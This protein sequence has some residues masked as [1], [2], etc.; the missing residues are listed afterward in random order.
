M[1]V[2]SEAFLQA[3]VESWMVRGMPSFEVVVAQT[4]LP[5]LRHRS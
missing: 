3:F 4:I 5:E 1:E 2:C